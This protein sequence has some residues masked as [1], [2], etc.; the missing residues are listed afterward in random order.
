[1]LPGMCTEAVFFAPLLMSGPLCLEKCRFMFP[2]Q[3]P[4]RMPVILLLPEVAY[5]F[6]ERQRRIFLNINISFHAAVLEGK[7]SRGQ[8]GRLDS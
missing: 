6:R 2:A 4:A 3:A 5:C 8:H 1:M 7:G